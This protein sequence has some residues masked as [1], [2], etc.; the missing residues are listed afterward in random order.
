ME[1]VAM[2]SI[3][4]VGMAAATV[5]VG[6]AGAIAVFSPYRRHDPFEYALLV[7]RREIDAACDSVFSYLGTSAH[8]HEWSVFVSHITP[9]NVG[10]VA[11]GAVGSIRRSFKR[12]DETGMQWDEYFTA[13]RAGRRRRLRIFNLKDAPLRS[14]TPLMTEQIYEPTARGC[15]LA[16]TLFFEGRPTL[17]DEAKMR[18]AAYEIARIFRRNMGNIKRLTEQRFGATHLSAGTHA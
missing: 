12:A 13:V 14:D 11:D 15:R 10:T 3:A 4:F 5:V 7:E 16:F 9:L 8:A 18:V 17:A 2:R 6:G 1:G